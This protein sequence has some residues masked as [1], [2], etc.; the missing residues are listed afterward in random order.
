MQAEHNSIREVVA[1]VNVERNKNK[2]GD[3]EKITT[4]ERPTTI[5]KF[6]KFWSLLEKLG[7]EDEG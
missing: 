6:A 3:N 1:V 2:L 7:G 5:L 4:E